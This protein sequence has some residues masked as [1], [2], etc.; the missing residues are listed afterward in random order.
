MEILSLETGETPRL[1]ITT[2]G[3]DLRLTGREGRTIE[4]QAARRGGLALHPHG[5][6]F[7]LACQ[8]A[9]LV[10]L[11]PGA[12][13]EVAAVGGDARVTG[14]SGP[15]HIETVGGDLLLRRV[16]T[17]V[18]Q[19]LGGDLS[20]SR[21]DGDFSAEWIGGDAK[22]EQVDGQV[23]LASVGSDLVLQSADQ[24][25][26]AV[27]GGDVRLRFAPR[28]GTHSAIQAGGDLSCR[29]PDEASV[30]LRLRAGGDLELSPRWRREQAGDAVV[31]E[32]G[33]GEATIELSAGGDLKVGGV[34]AGM[35]TAL[36]MD[37]GEQIR[38]RV[39]AEMEAAMAQVEASL[40]AM[41]A[42]SLGIDT[43]RLARNLRRSAER[44]QR[45]AA[46]ARQRAEAKPARVRVSVDGRPS[47]AGR[48]VAFDFGRVGGSK[49][50][51]SEE[52]RLAVLRMLEQGTITVGEA[53]KLLQAL[54]SAV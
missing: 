15:I 16:G 28:P 4:A 14:V 43:E 5:D 50:P 30:R 52:E 2:I 18:I 21:V 54:E 35:W 11:P 36:D 23:R 12:Q 10:F 9:C 51:A 47:G 45:K 27:I 8:S 48:G 17:I 1:R 29:L 22:I 40:E 3:G 53:E 33:A 24:G 42:S 49:A 41:E 7:E 31:A 6:G 25:V 13:V 39:E 46:R 32:L 34:D 20:A 26:E 44:A 37:L 19:R 38:S